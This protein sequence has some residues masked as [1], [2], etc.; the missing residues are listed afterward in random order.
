LTRS[1]SLPL[2]LVVAEA[3]RRRADA[4]VVVA[5]DLTLL[6]LPGFSADNRTRCRQIVRL[7]AEMPGYR[8]VVIPPRGHIAADSR[9]L[10]G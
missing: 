4:L 10:R 8:S 5:D 1:S 9:L 3:R 6:R 7:F 2:R